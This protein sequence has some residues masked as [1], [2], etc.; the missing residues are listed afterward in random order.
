MLLKYS[1]L[2]D[3]S[4]AMTVAIEAATLSEERKTADCEPE[5]LP[6]D[7]LFRG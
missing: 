4:E 6:I 1:D 3:P 7:G 5:Y 2:T